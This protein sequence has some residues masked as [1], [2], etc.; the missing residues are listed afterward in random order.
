[1]TPSPFVLPDERPVGLR[2][3][4]SRLPWYRID[5]THPDRWGWGAFDQPRHRFDPA[6]G[7]FRVRYAASTARGAARERFPERRMSA[8]DGALWMVRLDGDLRLLDLCSE[9]T[10]DRLGIDDR[11]ST[12]RL[13]RARTPTTPDPFLDTCGRLA[14]LTRDWWAGDVPAI[15]FRSRP[16]PATSRTSP[17]ARPRPGPTCL[18]GRCASPRISSCRSPWGTA[19][20]SPR[21]GSPVRPRRRRCR[22]SS[23]RPRDPGRCSRG[24]RGHCRRA[25]GP[26][27]PRRRRHGRR[28]RRCRR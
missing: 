23:R 13:P 15:R 17:S 22:S 14:D 1:M 6:S 19:S 16:A 5:A 3:R 2:T 21:R 28:S 9:A 24:S 11:I 12:S 26:R 27:W 25:R 8:A 7:R 18:L 20:R 4:R 10:L